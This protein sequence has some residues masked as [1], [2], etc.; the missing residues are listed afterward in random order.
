M[1]ITVLVLANLAVFGVYWTLQSAQTAFRENVR[2]APPEVMPELNIR[3]VEDIDPITFLVIGS[4]SRA[5]LDSLQNFGEASGERSDVIML[6]KVYP[7]KGTAQILSLPRDLL[8]EI[9]GHGTNR[10]NAAYAFGGAPL[11]VRTVKSVT[12]LPI[13]HYVEVDFVGFQS[14]V[15]EVG[16]VTIDFPNRARDTKSGLDVSAGSIQLDGPEALAY[17]RSRSYQEFQDGRWVSV[18][19]SDIGRTARQQQLVL[20]IISALKTP[21]TLTETGAVVSSFASH[22][23]VDS[24][25]LESSLIQLA[26]QM[27]NVSAERIETATLATY[28]DSFSGMSILR[29]DQPTADAMIASFANGVPMS[30][31]SLEPLRLQVLNGNGVSGS[32][33]DW[34]EILERKG[35]DILDVG[36]AERTD[37]AVTTVIVRPGSIV[38]GQAIIDALGFGVLAP[39]S[40]DSSL[41]AIVIVGLDAD[42]TLQSG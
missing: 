15:D 14:I 18:D 27:R 13:H 39:G 28:G 38:Q 35:F 11:M 4:D 8:V 5:R 3:P 33:G 25:L 40:L 2:E 42:R 36:D 21:S 19:A 23:T 22:L 29:M 7:E 34:S 6:V 16:G 10:I 24:A 32:A 31:V 9:P 37:F 1:I 17:A 20:A 12:G 26:F 30:V 41:D